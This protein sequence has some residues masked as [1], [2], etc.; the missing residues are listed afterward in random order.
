MRISESSFVNREIPSALRNAA[1]FLELG[2][3]MATIK[4]KCARDGVETSG[5]NDFNHFLNLNR[6]G[7]TIEQCFKNQI[8]RK[9]SPGLKFLR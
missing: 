9:S 4:I 3:D 5:K 8:I 1:L 6:S 2:S 7:S